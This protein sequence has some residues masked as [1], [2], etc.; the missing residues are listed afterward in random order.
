MSMDVVYST[1]P[2]VSCLGNVHPL[3]FWASQPLESFFQNVGFGQYG[4]RTHDI[5]VISTTL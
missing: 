1:I 3:M 4:G 2:P 5:R